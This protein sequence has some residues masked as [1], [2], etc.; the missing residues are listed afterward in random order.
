MNIILLYTKNT[1]PTINILLL[2]VKIYVY[3]D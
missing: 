1:L 2:K 3:I